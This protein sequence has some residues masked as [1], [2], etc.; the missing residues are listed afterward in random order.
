M[1]A[2]VVSGAILAN[3]AAFGAGIWL[4]VW[5]SRRVP[6]RLSFP[7]ANPMGIAVMMWSLRVFVFIICFLTVTMPV[8]SVSQAI[9]GD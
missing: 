2:F 5:A 9:V 4:G 7:N 6:L 8:T 3:I 1:H